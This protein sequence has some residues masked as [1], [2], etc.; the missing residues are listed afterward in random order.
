M[1]GN[2]IEKNWNWNRKG[3]CK[4]GDLTLFNEEKIR[5]KRATTNQANKPNVTV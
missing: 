4:K 3:I 1:P 2:D 5:R